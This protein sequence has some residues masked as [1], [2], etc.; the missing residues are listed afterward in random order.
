MHHTSCR[1]ASRCRGSVLIVALVLSSIFLVI[2]V[3]LA[4]VSSS[5][6]R[7]STATDNSIVAFEVAETGLEK[8]L[9]QIYPDDSALNAETV[10]TLNDFADKLKESAVS[11]GCGDGVVTVTLTNDR[12]YN[13]IFLDRSGTPKAITNCNEKLKDASDASKNTLRKGMSG[14]RAQG[15]YG[16]TVRAVEAQIVN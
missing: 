12:K 16:N 15:I 7:S 14:I 5:E 2:A 6:T 8:A 3:S 1:S 9:S 13:L 11:G 4:K 10:V